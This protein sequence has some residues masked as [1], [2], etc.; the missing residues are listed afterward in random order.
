MRKQL[1]KSNDFSIINLFKLI[2][3][4]NKGYLSAESI[5]Q[6]FSDTLIYDNL[7]NYYAR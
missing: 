6:Y 7:V 1:A 3:N 4:N 2:D 5:Q